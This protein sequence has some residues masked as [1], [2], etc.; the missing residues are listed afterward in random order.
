[1][2][3][4]AGRGAGTPLRW[5][6][7]PASFGKPRKAR[8]LLGPLFSPLLK[9]VYIFLPTSLPVLTFHHSASGECQRQ[10]GWLGH[11]KGFN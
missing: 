7:P 11:T 1:M 5:P 8:G 3:K 6:L 4:L 9:G 10:A 2:E